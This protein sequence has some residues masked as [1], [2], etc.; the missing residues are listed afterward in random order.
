ML[1]LVQLLMVANSHRIRFLTIGDGI[2]RLHGSA[3]LPVMK[4]VQA[5]LSGSKPQLLKL[6]EGKERRAQVVMLG[7]WP[8]SRP[9]F[10]QPVSYSEGS[11]FFQ[12]VPAPEA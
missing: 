12:I 6:L 3:P 2:V 8:P 1:D 9:G 10:G 7:R 5:S 4:E 11:E